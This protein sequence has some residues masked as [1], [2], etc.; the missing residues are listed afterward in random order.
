VSLPL[1]V[2]LAVWWPMKWLQHQQN[3]LNE[4][5]NIRIF[6]LLLSLYAADHDGHLPWGVT[7]SGI[8]ITNQALASEVTTANQ[9]F[10]A[11]AADN[12]PADD[13]WNRTHGPSV[14]NTDTLRPY[15]GENPYSYFSGNKWGENPLSPIASSFTLRPWQ[16]L[17]GRGWELSARDIPPWH[18]RLSVSV[19]WADGS[20]G[21]VNPDDTGRIFLADTNAGITTFALYPELPPGGPMAMAPPIR[22]GWCLATAIVTLFL[23]V[24]ALI[25]ILVGFPRWRDLR[26]SV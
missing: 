8:L 9:A 17:R 16:C 12:L 14:Q 19:L 6:G 13:L 26:H 20:A 1:L 23:T 11:L 5:E 7:E 24:P 15:A 10:R 2:L 21:Q 4:V 3:G 18:H 22:W 25:V